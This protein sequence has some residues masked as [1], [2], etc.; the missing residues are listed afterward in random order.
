MDCVIC[1]YL[2][3]TYINSQITPKFICIFRSFFFFFFL[4]YFSLIIIIIYLFIYYLLAINI[5]KLNFEGTLLLLFTF[6]IFW[7]PL[8]LLPNWFAFLLYFQ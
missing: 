8:K 2:K 3:Y 6:Y 1:E 5:Q 4:L 7:L